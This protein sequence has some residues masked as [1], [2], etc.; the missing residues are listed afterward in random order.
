MATVPP[1]AVAPEPLKDDVRVTMIPGG[2]D[3]K[4]RQGD[5][6]RQYS[7]CTE[8]YVCQLTEMLTYFEYSPNDIACLVRRCQYNDQQIQVAVA[9]IIEEQA[10]HAQKSWGVVRTKKRTK[11]GKTERARTER[12]MEDDCAG[13]KVEKVEFESTPAPRGRTRP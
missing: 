8:F 2:L 11:K 13:E 5:D 3:G 7:P 12:K 1:N 4:I 9:E 6:G 10:N